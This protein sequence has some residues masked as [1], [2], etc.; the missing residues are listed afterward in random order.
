M[1]TLLSFFINKLIF[2]E[3]KDICFII[4][5]G[6]LFYKIITI[7]YYLLP[8]STPSNLCHQFKKKSS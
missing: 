8:N 3:T 7:S 1:D 6:K 4:F 2:F 5:T